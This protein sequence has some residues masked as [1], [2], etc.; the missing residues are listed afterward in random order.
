VKRNGKYRFSLQFAAESDEHIKAGELLERLGNRKSAVVVDAL[1][2][3]IA[4]HPE[5]TGRAIG[6]ISVKIDSGIRREM[7]ETMIRSLIDER[8]KEI[9]VRGGQYTSG[10]RRMYWIRGSLRSSVI[11]T[12]LKCE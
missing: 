7:L 8:V 1:N 11:W 9:G 6:R 4:S 12:C 3:Y 2:E 10:N 5:L